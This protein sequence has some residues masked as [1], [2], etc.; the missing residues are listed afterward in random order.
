MAANGRTPFV[1]VSEW[2]NPKT[3]ELHVF[4]SDNVWFD[5]LI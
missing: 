5:L 2:E 4:T 1:V 3:S